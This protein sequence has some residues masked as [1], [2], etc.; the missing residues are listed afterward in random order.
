MTSSQSDQHERAMYELLGRMVS[1]AAHLELQ[2]QMLATRLVETPYAAH[3]VNGQ[4]S[5]MVIKL[6]G[7]VAKEHPGVSPEQLT[8]LQVTLTECSRLFSRRH[9]YVHG[10]WSVAGAA[11]EESAA[12]QTMRFTRGKQRPTFAPL[13][14]DDLADLIRRL[15]E[16]M[17][18][19]M[20]WLIGHIKAT[21]GDRLVIVEP[22]GES[23][24][25]NSD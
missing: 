21:S 23:D 1:T 20:A 7:D 25:P 24:T 13:S 4:N 6:I 22:E 17:T 9:G 10:A 18:E 3:W 2:L 19:V 11:P 15:D 5:S 12:W 8:E 16:V 14:L